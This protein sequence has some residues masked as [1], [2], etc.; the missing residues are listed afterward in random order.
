MSEPSTDDGRVTITVY[1]TAQDKRD[2]LQ[3][4]GLEAETGAGFLRRIGT[5][6]AREMLL[7]DARKRVGQEATPA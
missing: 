2:I 6:T 3:A 7:D 5:Q 4:A 1:M